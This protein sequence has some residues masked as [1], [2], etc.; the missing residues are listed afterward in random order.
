MAKMKELERPTVTQPILDKFILMIENVSTLVDVARKT[1]GFTK[2]CSK[3][4]S[5]LLPALG[6]KKCAPASLPPIEEDLLRGA[7]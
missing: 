1:Q 4:L 2:Y 5:T 6:G 7:F 3:T